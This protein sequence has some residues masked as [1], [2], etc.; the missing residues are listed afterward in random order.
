[1][2]IVENLE[3]LKINAYSQEL[4]KI[5][6]LNIKTLRDLKKGLHHDG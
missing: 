2:K 3:S 1:M 6:Q 4:D 5:L